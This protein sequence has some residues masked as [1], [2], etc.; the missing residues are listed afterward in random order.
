MKIEEYCAKL[1][2]QLGQR[3][4]RDER[5]ELAVT[6]L[7]K[8]FGVEK[9]EIGIFLLCEK[10][11][12]LRFVWPPALRTAGAIPLTSRTSLVAATAR[13]NAPSLD[14]SFAVTPHAFYF[15]QMGKQDQKT[16]GLAIQK[17]MSV[18]LHKDGRVTGVAQV[19]RKGS[20]P[21]E[22]GKDFTQTELHALAKIGQVLGQVL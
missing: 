2:E 12:E 17:I 10:G 7:G 16:G 19:A 9:G 6:A 13:Q 3:E 1:A 18:P 22:A 8:A 4:T 15:E 21:A 20:S 14:N 5:L 11:D